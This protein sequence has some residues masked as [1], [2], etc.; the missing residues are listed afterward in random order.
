MV[1]S[2][3]TLKPAAVVPVEAIRLAVLA[4]DA[5]TCKGPPTMRAVLAMVHVVLVPMVTVQVAAP[6]LIDTVMTEPFGTASLW[7]VVTVGVKIT[8]ASLP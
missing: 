6:E 4:K 7:P 1:A 3:V 5:L 8:L 2:A